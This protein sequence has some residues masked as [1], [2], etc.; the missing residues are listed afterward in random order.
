MKNNV[1]SSLN[2]DNSNVQQIPDN[3]TTRGPELPLEEVETTL[4]DYH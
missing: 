3:L 2:R 1:L 4:V